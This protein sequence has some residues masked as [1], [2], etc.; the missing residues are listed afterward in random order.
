MEESW[1]WAISGVGEILY[2]K[3]YP[4]SLYDGED[5]SILGT[6]EK[7]GEMGVRFY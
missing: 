7:F 2:I 3:P 4:Y 1:T 5:S 6:N